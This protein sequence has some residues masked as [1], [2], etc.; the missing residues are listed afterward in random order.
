MTEDINALGDAWVLRIMKN[1]SDLDPNWLEKGE[2]QLKDGS[3]FRFC[4]GELKMF[5]SY[6][7]ARQQQHVMVSGDDIAVCECNDAIGKENLDSSEDGRLLPVDGYFEDSHEWLSRRL[8]ED[9]GAPGLE[10][11]PE[12][13]AREVEEFQDNLPSLETLFSSD[14][15]NCDNLYDMIEKMKMFPAQTWKFKMID[16]NVKGYS[17]CVAFCIPT[18]EGKAGLTAMFPEWFVNGDSLLEDHLMKLGIDH[19]Q[20]EALN[21]AYRVSAYRQL[22]NGKILLTASPGLVPGMMQYYAFVLCKCDANHPHDGLGIVKPPDKGYQRRYPGK[23]WFFS[24]IMQRNLFLMVL[25]H[26][27]FYGRFNLLDHYCVGSIKKGWAY[28]ELSALS[29]IK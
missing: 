15:V 4:A 5:R 7:Q 28:D 12:G 27:H 9:E 13:L 16:G 14:H 10:V 29:V 23:I 26:L 20:G 19:C 17:Q 24:S 8:D 1:Y 22:D 21:E 3:V 11:V 18:G 2:V 25:A 6:A